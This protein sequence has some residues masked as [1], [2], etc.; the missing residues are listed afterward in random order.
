VQKSADSAIVFTIHPD[1]RIVP[2]WHRLAKDGR[3]SRSSRPAAAMLPD[4]PGILRT[5]T[6][7]GRTRVFVRQ[8]AAPAALPLFTE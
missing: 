5:W 3:P 6:P 1:G 4:W 2:T 7:R 8:A